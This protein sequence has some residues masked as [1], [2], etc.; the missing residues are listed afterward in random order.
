MFK[1]IEREERAV[2]KKFTKG[3]FNNV[4][5]KAKKEE[6]RVRSRPVP[7]WEKRIFDKH[8]TKSCSFRNAN[9]ELGKFTPEDMFDFIT[10]HV[11]DMKECIREILGRGKSGIRANIIAKTWLV[12]RQTLKGNL[13]TRLYGMFTDGVMNDT[14]KQ[15][16]EEI[17]F[18][19]INTKKTYE[20]LYAG[21]NLD[22]FI[23][24]QATQNEN[25]IDKYIH[26]GTDLII[27]R[28]EGVYLRLLKDVNPISAGS[29]IDLPPWIKNKQCC[30]NPKNTQDHE[31][32]KHTHNK[33]TSGHAGPRP[34][35]PS[36]FCSFTIK[37]PITRSE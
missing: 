3:V 19:H 24:N 32:S 29:F 10:H 13:G 20:Y 12:H 34:N 25:Q 26:E 35:T 14:I 23:S 8:H 33:D 30:I 16:I 36:R 22:K 15:C 6:D 27:V 31:C 17:M 7:Q 21:D 28:I 4:L 9:A 37:Y 1:S 2:V 11:N 5:K 18:P